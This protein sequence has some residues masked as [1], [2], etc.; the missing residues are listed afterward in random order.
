MAADREY[1]GRDAKDADAA[2]IR[3]LQWIAG[4]LLLLNGGALILSTRAHAAR[5][6][7]DAPGKSWLVGLLCALLGGILWALAYASMMRDHETREAR[8]GAAADRQET[9]DLARTLGALAIML[10]VASLTGFITGCESLSRLPEENAVRM[11]A[12]R[13]P[14][15]R[16]AQAAAAAAPTATPAIAEK[17][18]VQASR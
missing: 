18:A 6:L 10:W 13:P 12:H 9:G 17:V 5:G 2:T 11:A 16:E 8:I 14:G 7:F 15:V 4:A 3:F 1:P